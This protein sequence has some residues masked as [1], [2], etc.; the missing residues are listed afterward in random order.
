MNINARNYFIE[1]LK[2]NDIIFLYTCLYFEYN[3]PNK[4]HLSLNDFCNLFHYYK[5]AYIRKN[6]ITVK[7]V[8]LYLLINNLKGFYTIAEIHTFNNTDGNNVVIY[9]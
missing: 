9:S 7:C 4:L 8:D 1:Y 3:I 5:D 2:T 6:G